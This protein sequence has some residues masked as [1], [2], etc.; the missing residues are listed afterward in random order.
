MTLAYNPPIDQ[1]YGSQY[2][3]TN[4]DV[5]FGTYKHNK[6]GEL[7]FSGQVPLEEEWS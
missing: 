3:R 6:K 1:N 5:S 4:I 2:C 7:K